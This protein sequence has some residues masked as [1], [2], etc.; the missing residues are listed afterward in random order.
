MYNL[1]NKYNAAQLFVSEKNDTNLDK[2]LKYSMDLFYD[3]NT[4]ECSFETDEFVNM[5]KLV[6]D[7]PDTF[8]MISNDE[9]NDKLKKREVLLED[10]DSLN[11]MSIKSLDADFNDIEKEYFGYPSK[12]HSKATIVFNYSMAMNRNSDN[13]DAAWDFIKYYLENFEPSMLS[14]FENGFDLQLD[15]A[16]NEYA[17]DH[18]AQNPLG[19]NLTA[20]QADTLRG[21]VY[22]A[23]GYKQYDRAIYNIV[24][25]EVMSFISG[26]RSAEEA[27]KI[28]QNRVKLYLDEQN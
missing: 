7:I 16:M 28:I 15:N 14:V 22:N 3:K 20:E 23:S 19:K 9:I 10:V 18:A 6:N 13:K 11:M 4:G 27:V 1:L 17:D 12:S 21:L 5:L 8:T 2:F 24:Y 26:Q 25:E